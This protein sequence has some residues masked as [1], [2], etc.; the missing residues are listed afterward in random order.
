MLKAE[1]F[2]RRK[3]YGTKNNPVNWHGIPITV[4]IRELPANQNFISKN[5]FGIFVPQ[6]QI[7]RNNCLLTKGN[8]SKK[9][10]ITTAL[11]LYLLCIV[12]TFVPMLCS[13]SVHSINS[14]HLL[15]I[16]S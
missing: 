13:A 12:Y 8:Q 10:S 9:G 5:S 3:I 16:G 2:S 4:S 7:H 15:C 14:F 6:T 11:Q 1:Y